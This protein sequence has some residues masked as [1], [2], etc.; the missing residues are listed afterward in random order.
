MSLS[1]A[2]VS[3]IRPTLLKPLCDDQA[4]TEDDIQEDNDAENEEGE[5]IEVPAPKL[6]IIYQTVSDILHK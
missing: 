5:V 2:N 4:L 3:M 1:S 6:V